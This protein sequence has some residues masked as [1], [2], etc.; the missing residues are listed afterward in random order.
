MKIMN[1]KIIKI[2]RNLKN[3]RILQK[4]IELRTKYI[5]DFKATLISPL[6][7]TEETLHKIYKKLVFDMETKL[8][9]LQKKFDLLNDIID[10]LDGEERSVIYFR[11]ILGINW[12]DIPEYMMYEQRSCQNFESNAIKK[13]AKM[14]IDWGD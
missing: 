11:Y 10:K 6:P 2:R 9:L 5:A 7:K 13:I 8:R 1:N 14:K 12:V 4:E 3:Y